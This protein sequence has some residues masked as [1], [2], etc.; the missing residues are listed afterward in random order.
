MTTGFRFHPFE[1]LVATMVGMILIVAT[2]MPPAG[3]F[4]F[5]LL[6][7]L[8]G[9]GSHANANLP[10]R[11]DRVCRWFFITPGLHRIHH[12]IEESHQKS[13]LGVVFPWW[14]RCFGTYSEISDAGRAPME[15]GL[16]SFHKALNVPYLLATPFLKMPP[17]EAEPGPVGARQSRSA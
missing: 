12:S 8:Q 13:N 11:W 17:A 2:A 10:A 9:L 4:L 14:D 16:R 15:F 6:A 5:G 1:T 7:Q 3:V